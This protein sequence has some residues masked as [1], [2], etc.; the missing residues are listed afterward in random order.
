MAKIFIS[1]SSKDDK[2]AKKLASDLTKL[3]H[4]PWLDKWQIKVGECIPSKI[5]QGISD[6]DYIIVVLSNNSVKSGW[7]DR[8]WKIMYWKEIEEGE[9]LILP[10]L[11]EQCK[12]PTLLK[13]RKYANFSKNYALG[14]VE[15]ASSINPIIKFS[16]IEDIKTA[17]FSSDI[18]NLISRTQNRNIPLSQ[19]ITEA[20]ELALKMKNSILESFCRKELTGWRQGKIDRKEDK[21]PTYR[22]IETFVSPIAQINLQYFGWGGNVSNIFDYMRRES[23]YFFPSKIFVP[24]SISEIESKIH[25]DS[26]K[27]IMTITMK[28]KDFIPNSDQPDLP[29]FVYFRPNSYLNVLE[30]IRVELIKRLLDLLPQVENK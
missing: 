19:S 1:Y 14:L 24:D 16:K 10:V 23:E 8:E 2:F 4:K 21:I 6:A 3:G 20:L 9:S 22:L 30:S 13:T 26:Q 5:E 11:I 15:L 27:G 12:I 28:Q 18:S 7:L 17:N 29:V 25:I